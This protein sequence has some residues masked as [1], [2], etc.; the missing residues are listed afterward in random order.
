LGGPD[1]TLGIAYA[2]LIGSSRQKIDHSDIAEAYLKFQLHRSVD[3]T[4]DVQYE[5]LFVTIAEQGQAAN[6][7]KKDQ[8]AGIDDQLH[9]PVPV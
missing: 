4:V 8:G 1:D 7:V 5:N 6:L 3:F 2:R 9:R